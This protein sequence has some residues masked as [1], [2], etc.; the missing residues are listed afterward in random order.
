VSSNIV[1]LQ[2]A[3]PETPTLR[4]NYYAM[5][6]YVEPPQL[7][8]STGINDT[9]ECEFELIIWGLEAERVGD[10]G[11]LVS[12]ECCAATAGH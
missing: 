11:P 4:C 5:Q 2:N 12:L 6:C 1:S 7:A 8:L 10:T 3:A 9:V